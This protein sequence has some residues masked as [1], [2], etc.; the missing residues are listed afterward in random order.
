M[1]VAR[2]FWDHENGM[3]GYIAIGWGT[4]YEVV[5]AAFMSCATTIR[6]TDGVLYPSNEPANANYGVLR[7]CMADSCRKPIRGQN[8]PNGNGARVCGGYWAFVMPRSRQ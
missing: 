6:D 8:E 4:R 3:I 7:A 1:A 5:D 2:R